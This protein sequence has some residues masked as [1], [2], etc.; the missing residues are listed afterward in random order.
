MGAPAD[1]NRLLEDY[2]SS[3]SRESLLALLVAHQDRVYNVC[4]QVLGRAEDAEDASQETLLKLAEGARSATDADALA[5]WIYRV[6]LRAALDLWRRRE[7]ARHHEKRSAM[8]RPSSVPFD[9]PERRALFEAMERL[10]DGD[11]TLVMQHYFEKISLEELGARRGL[12]AVAIWKRID[13]AR[14][15]LK[16]ALLGAGFV[17]ASARL[18]DALESAVPAAAPASLVG[19]AIVGKILAGGMAVGATKS[20]IIPAVVVAMLLLFAISTGGYVALR[21]RGCVTPPAPG[22]A[23]TTKSQPVPAPAPHGTPANSESTVRKSPDSKEALLQTLA[24]YQSWYDEYKR[25]LT[26]P[27]PADD[28]MHHIRL[29][30]EG[31]KQFTEARARIFED[32][33]TFLDF[34]RDPANETLVVSGMVGDLLN[35]NKQVLDGW[36]I[37]RQY[38]KEFPP[39]LLDGLITTLRS[40]SVAV[41][42]GILGFFRNVHDVPA[43]YDA[44]FLDLVDDPN[45]SVQTTALWALWRGRRLDPSVLEKIRQKA[46]TT[47]DNSFRDAAVLAIRDSPGPETN[48]WMLERFENNKDDSLN[49]VLAHAASKMASIGPADGP[50]MDRL[51]KRLVQVI[52]KAEDLYL[53]DL[54]NSAL[55]LPPAYSSR[56]FE[57]VQFHIA[58]PRLKNGVKQVL[59]EARA[60]KATAEELQ[61]LFHRA[62]RD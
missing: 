22:Q 37:D 32:P 56:V 4:F 11:R 26:Q 40:G 41:K 27:I 25:L 58:N 13:R 7:T 52:N 48:Q 14:E 17:A 50:L 2:K 33:Q 36:F 44:L 6:S 62:T 45:P 54:L 38:Y 23:A 8:N 29:R 42:T 59:E 49:R 1:E 55:M 21:S 30:Y 53:K 51:V 15:T 20:S 35:K 34:V 18:A 16:R 9:D 28:P 46:D 3:G 60:G 47:F 61:H 10:A 31:F 43:D 24:R 12:S 57:F 5:G 39:A 19:E